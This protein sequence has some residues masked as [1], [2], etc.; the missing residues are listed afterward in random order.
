MANETEDRCPSCGALIERPS[1]TIQIQ[2]AEREE[3]NSERV[4]V[5]ITSYRRK[6]LDRGNLCAKYF[7][8]ALRYSR[9]IRDDTEAEIIEKV[10]QIKVVSKLDERTE[11]EITYP[12]GYI[13]AKSLF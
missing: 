13:H 8:D 10:Q 9:L 11:I 1:G 6:L 4:L 2:G 5:S 3:E 7:V 12:Q